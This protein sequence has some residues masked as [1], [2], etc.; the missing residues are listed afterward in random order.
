MRPE[1]PA[2]SGRTHAGGRHA[3]CTRA[4]LTVANVGCA[5]SE[6]LLVL[7]ALHCV[8]VQRHAVDCT[9]GVRHTGAAPALACSGRR[10][11]QQHAF[12]QTPTQQAQA[13]LPAW[14]AGQQ[15]T[16]AG[17]SLGAPWLPQLKWMPGAHPCRTAGSRRRQAPLRPAAQPAPRSGAGQHTSRPRPSAAGPA[18]AEAGASAALTSPPISMGVRLTAAAQVR[19]CWSG[20]LVAGDP[21]WQQTAHALCEAPYPQWRA[22]SPARPD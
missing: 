10:G 19:P 3:R 11:M 14:P 6:L 9:H 18:S 17:T 8:A 7:D 13:S 4:G 5:H 2:I 1:I 12:L 22:Q 15:H 21:P 16:G 20:R